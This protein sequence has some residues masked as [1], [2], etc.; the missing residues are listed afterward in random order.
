MKK[1]VS[2]ALASTAALALSACG[3]SE[4]AS[5]EAE[6]ENVEIPAEE[7]VA[8]IDEMPIEDSGAVQS[9]P[10]A[11]PTSEADRDDEAPRP[12]VAREADDAGAAAAAA[13][14]DV[15]AIARDAGQRGEEAIRRE[16]SAAV[17]RAAEAARREIE[18]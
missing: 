9:G 17:D 18:N 4:D 14:A 3:S 2:I 13:A 12:S 7:A 16:G 1:F 6:A 10:A 5:V 8:E 11:V 15:R